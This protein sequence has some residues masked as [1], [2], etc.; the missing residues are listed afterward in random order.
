MEPEQALQNLDQASAALQL[1]REQHL[2]LA[3]SVAVLRDAL[4]HYRALSNPVM[5]NIMGNPSCAEA[6][7]Q[8]QAERLKAV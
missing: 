2:I 3:R 1:N 5:Q 7:M 4:A 6:E 8:A